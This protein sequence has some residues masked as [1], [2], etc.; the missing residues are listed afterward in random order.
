MIPGFP[1]FDLWGCQH[2]GLRTLPERPNDL[3]AFEEI[4]SVGAIHYSS[5]M[6]PGTSERATCFQ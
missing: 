4:M 3:G 6:T 1:K 5:N 2:E